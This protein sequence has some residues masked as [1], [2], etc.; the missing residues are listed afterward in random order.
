MGDRVRERAIAYV[1][2]LGDDVKPGK[3]TSFPQAIK[4]RDDDVVASSWA[5]YLAGRA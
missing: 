1:N 2:G 4:L 3:E 5:V